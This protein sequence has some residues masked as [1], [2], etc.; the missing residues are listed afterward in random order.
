VNT[1]LTWLK[2]NAGSHLLGIALV[3]VGL[4]GF[5]AYLAEHDA[6]LIADGEIANAQ[7]VIAGLQAKQADVTKTAATAVK[8]LQ[9]TAAQVK[10]PEQAVSLMPEVTTVPIN[11]VITPNEPGRAT[12]DALPLYTD[13]NQ[14][15]QDAVSLQACQDVA[16]LQKAVDAQKDVEISALKAK[17]SFWKRFGK[18]LKIVGCAGAGAAVGS[19]TKTPNGAALGGAL[20]AGVCQIF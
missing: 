6:R 11:A 17:P 4:L 10:T 13:L 9:K 12:V 7:T 20:G 14:C 18:S 5:R 2:T 3:A 8:V 16:E 1:I 19:L 15:R